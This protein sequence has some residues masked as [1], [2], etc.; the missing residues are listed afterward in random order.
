MLSR[1]K[2]IKLAA[3]A[4]ILPSRKVRAAFSSVQSSTPVKYRYPVALDATKTFLV[5]QFGSPCFACGDAPQIAP[6]MLGTSD[7]AS[8]LADRAA[9]GINIGWMI[10]A[11]NVYQTSPPNNVFGNAPFSGADFTNFNTAFW[12]YIDY[13]MSRTPANGM[14]VLAMPAFMGLNG[15]QGYQTSWKAASDAV[16]QGYAAFLGARYNSSICPN[17]VWAFGGD[18]DPADTALYAKLN[19]FAVALKAADPGHLMTL[20][21]SRFTGGSGAPNGGYSSV[22][23]ITLALGS[24]PSWLDI[25]WVYQ[26]GPT[27]LSG[28]Q[29]CY[30]QGYPCLLGEDW[31]E[32]D[33]SETGQSLRQEGY[34]AII[35]GC[36]LGRLMGNQQIWP[37]N[38][39][40]G[41][42][43]VVTPTWQSQLSS[44]GSV[45]Q[46]FAGN[47]FRS[48]P[49]QKM[50]PDLTAAVMTSNSGGAGTAACTRASDGSWIAAYAA[51]QQNLTFD[52]SKITDAGSQVLA[53][54]YD[55]ATG[56][57]R[58]AGLFPNSGSQTFT[59]PS[60]LT[61]AVLDL[62]SPAA[63]FRPPGT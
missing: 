9:R 4:L 19:T 31:Y 20:E 35:G 53:R 10:F 6:N 15:S 48:R 59:V 50:A 42:G 21:A 61:D 39:P 30:A 7:L 49:F 56:A 28:A 12:N 55:P 17:L 23:A 44:V 51:S 8:Y 18:A 54:W 27:V 32:L 33:H 62:V 47:Y 63:G 2:F 41:N 25:N 58:A 24:V 45:G 29:R 37:F 26:T 16:L 46:Q 43:G 13:I 36:T 60:D 11:D 57:V 40:N 5:D 22:D 14:T 3:P 38:S 1:R 52:M 34:M